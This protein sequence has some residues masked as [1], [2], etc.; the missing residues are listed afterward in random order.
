VTGLQHPVP[1]PPVPERP[2]PLTHQLVASLRD[3]AALKRAE[4]EQC[5]RTAAML[6]RE[7]L[8]GQLP[9]LATGGQG[10][11]RSSA[12]AAASAGTARASNG[13]RT[14]APGPAADGRV[15]R[16]PARRDVG[17]QASAGRQPTARQAA[18]VELLDS[19]PTRVWS[20]REIAASTGLNASSVRTFLQMLSAQ[21]AIARSGVGRYQARS[22]A[23]GGRGRR[24][25][26]IAATTS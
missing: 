23:A 10:R 19:D 20:P 15:G 22:A 2:H 8:D 3:L 18:I 14:T 5:E 16:R 11:R 26:R 9:A 12:A 25:G 13:R 6:E 21:Q 7:L 4:A 24:G 17:G 1:F